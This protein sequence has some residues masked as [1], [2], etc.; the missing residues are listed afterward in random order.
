VAQQLLI[1][2]RI[3]DT[4]REVV[5]ENGWVRTK[6]DNIVQVGSGNAV[7]QSDDEVIDCAGATLIPGLIDAHA[8]MGLPELPHLVESL[9]T[10]VYAA[11]V[12]EVMKSAL[13]CGFTTVRDAG[14]TDASF[15][16][17]QELGM[18][19]GP[20]MLVSNGALS[21][22][23]GHSDMRMH[24]EFRPQGLGNGLYWPGVVVDGVSQVRW[25]AREVLRRGADQIK[26][27][28]GGG[29]ASHQDYIDDV[30]FSA[31]EIA[32]AVWEARGRQTYV[33]AHCYTPES[34][35]NAVDNGVRSIEHGNLLDE[36][37]A[38]RI[39]EKSA[40]YVPTLLVYERL[41]SH[42]R[43]RLSADQLSKVEYVLKHGYDAIKIAM[44]AGVYIG[45]GTDASS[46][47]AHEARMLG[48]ELHA[49]VQGA[50]GTLVSATKVNAELMGLGHRL[51]KIDVGY[52][53]DL[54]LINGNVEENIGLL[55]DPKNILL[56]IGDGRVAVDRV[57]A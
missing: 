24:H 14:F 57:N 16:R 38:Q 41:S 12:F 17:A 23:G 39:V 27:M 4:H 40:Y 42:A 55:Q 13:E 25:G 7:R 3:L 53:A 46:P 31:E 49:R 26:I 11:R 30:H 9:P 32:A 54:V 19:P 47:P 5:E 1:N 35:I 20:R 51:G 45:F 37:S 56:V 15:K 18:V 10:A 6:D 34:I 33:L 21:V 52:A 22:T 44:D 28:A 29:C 2:A 36:E 8:H 48:F 50:M 43:D